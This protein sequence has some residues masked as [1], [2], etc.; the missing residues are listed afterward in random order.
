[1]SVSANGRGCI[2]FDGLNRILQRQRDLDE[3]KSRR[4]EA[5][6]NAFNKEHRRAVSSRLVLSLEPVDDYIDIQL[7]QQRINKIHFDG[8]K[9]TGLQ[10]TSMIYLN[11][12]IDTDAGD[13]IF[14]SL[15]TQLQ[16]QLQDLI[17]SVNVVSVSEIPRESAN[18]NG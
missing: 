4:L 8:V 2:F 7:L 6:A 1:L 11:A 12:T 10:N 5:V 17:S 18:A 3:D 16:D 15:D 14:D 9:W 13:G